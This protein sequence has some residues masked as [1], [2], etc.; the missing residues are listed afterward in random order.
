MC[1][2]PARHVN[3]D[4]L[5]PLVAYA[6]APIDFAG[7]LRAGQIVT[8]GTLC[9]VVPLPAPGSVVT[10]LGALPPLAFELV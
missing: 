1:E 6:N 4:P 5:A 3:V 10:S 7:G 9:G 2:V 8:T